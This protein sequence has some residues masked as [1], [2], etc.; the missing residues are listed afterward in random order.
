MPGFYPSLP[1][2]QDTEPDRE[3]RA[4]ARKLA[5]DIEPVAESIR[6]RANHYEVAHDGF[7]VAFYSLADNLRLLAESLRSCADKRYPGPHPRPFQ[8]Y[9]GLLHDQTR[10]LHD[11][12]WT[13]DAIVIAGFRARLDQ[14]DGDWPDLDGEYFKLERAEPRLDDEAMLVEALRQH[15]THWTKPELAA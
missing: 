8:H 5:D 10:M 15:W 13:A 6:L 3:L 12:K 9:A 14:L 7:G 1:E 2:S 4:R 11:A